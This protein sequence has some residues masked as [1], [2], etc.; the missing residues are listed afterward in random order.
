[1]TTYNVIVVGGLCVYNVGGVR[2][3]Y[4]EFETLRKIL[5]N[6]YGS[7]GI[8]VPPL[9]PKR[10]VGNTDQEFVKSRMCG[11]SLFVEAIS[12]NPFLM[13]DTSFE[14][15]LMKAEG[16]DVVPMEPS[17]GASGSGSISDSTITN[18]AGN[19]GY[20]KWIEFLTSVELPHDAESQI[21]KVGRGDDGDIAKDNSLMHIHIIDNT[22]GYDANS[23]KAW[24]HSNVLLN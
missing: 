14:R 20:Q 21:Q 13:H 4:S 1:V 5:E 24:S 19:V 23:F 17:L 3:R 12:S 22:R 7:E 16:V 10:V 15:F 6:R 9:P 8:L 2:R 18:L 11:L